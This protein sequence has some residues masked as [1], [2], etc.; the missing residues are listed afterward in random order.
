V[1]DA[2]N[3]LLGAWVSLASEGR[4]TIEAMNAMGYDA[5]GVGMMEGIRGLDVLL[6]RA[7]EASFPI[8]SANLV[9]AGEGRLVL[10][11][12]T[13]I[14]R[15]GTTF[16][17]LGLTDR[18]FVQ[19][20]ELQSQ[21]VVQD[22]TEAAARYVPDLRAQADVIIVL[23]TLGRDA[24]QALA[25]AVSGIDVIVGA[26][27]SILM[28]EPLRSGS[29]LIVQQGYLGE[30]LGVAHIR[31]D[32]KG[33]L[34]E[35]TAR[36]VALTPDYADDPALAAIVAR[37]KQQYPTPTPRPTSALAPATPQPSN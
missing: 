11:P 37:Y 28:Q 10:E 22:P 30:W 32:A 34:V 9:Y 1:L 25:T 24:D 20:S 3:A 13:V 26:G 35:A 36:S 12:Y 6:A 19:G 8:L 27:S 23:S 17:I 29:S 31:Y 18:S 16:G 14:E 33:E 2:G 15:D 4:V 5:M 21:V 7:E